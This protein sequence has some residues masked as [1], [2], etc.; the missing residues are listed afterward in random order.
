M[1]ESIIIIIVTFHRN[2]SKHFVWFALIS[3]VSKGVTCECE[4]AWCDSTET[5]L[6]GENSKVEC[7]VGRVARSK[8]QQPSKQQYAPKEWIFDQLILDD[9]RNCSLFLVIYSGR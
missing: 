2:I 6:P 3:A 1:F 4:C 9:F 7:L 8:Y 5:H